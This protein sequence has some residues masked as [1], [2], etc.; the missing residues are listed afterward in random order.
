MKKSPV[1]ILFYYFFFFISCQINEKNN[2][3]NFGFERYD[4]VSYKPLDWIDCGKGSDISIDSSTVFEGN[5]SLKVEKSDVSGFGCY[6]YT[7]PVSFEGNE[8]KLTAF[9]KLQNVN[10]GFAGISLQIDGDEGVL[11]HDNMM[12]QNLHGTSDWGKYT[13]NLKL[14][15]NATKIHIGAYLTGGGNIWVDNFQLR[16]D[17]KDISQL[18]QK[19]KT[20]KPDFDFSE[21]SGVNL[22]NLSEV[23][24]KNAVVLGQIWGF[25]KYHH[26]MVMKGNFN[27]DYELFMIMQNV[28]ESKNRNERN[29]I[30][31][32]WI[33]GF[34]VIEN[35]GIEDTL[36][37]GKI[38]SNPNFSWMNNEEISNYPVAEE[39]KKINL[40]KSKDPQSYVTLVPGA[41]NPIF[42]NE[43]EYKN[44]GYP[45]A[46]FRLLAL[47]RFWN[48][49]QYFYPYFYLIEH[50]WN[51]VLYE[52]VPKFINASNELEYKLVLLELMSKVQDSHV[53][54][55]GN[56]KTLGQFWG[57][58][59]APLELRFIDE[60]LVITKILEPAIKNDVDIKIGDQIT[61]IDGIGIDEI[62]S[63]KLKYIPGSNRQTKLRDIARKIIRSNG[64]KMNLTLER[65]TYNWEIEFKLVDL[66]F[67]YQR[68]LESHKWVQEDIGYIYPGK[69]RQ[70]EIEDIMEKF[71]D[72]KGIIVDLRCYPSDFI[73]FSLGKYLMDK[74]RNFVKFTNANLNKPGLFTFTESLSVGEIN[75]NS[76]KGKVIIIIDETTQS[77]AEYTAM[78]LRVAPNALVVGSNSAGADGNV[79]EVL[80]PG[81]IVTY[82]TGIGVY[83]PDGTE[84]QRIGIVP[85]IEIK[86][87]IEG[88]RNN[89]DEPL[90]K[91]VE[92]I[93][94]K[95]RESP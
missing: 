90:T 91:A 65:T 88:I 9:L 15:D 34:G 62:L 5:Y 37:Q 54:I 58:K 28:Y 24:I 79:S 10:N 84:T 69:L 44:L 42:K 19:P 2:I 38:K 1:L 41:R 95:L 13:I 29:L 83:Y 94:G 39:L 30:L 48:I 3:Y 21:N 87:T 25:L 78:A 36:Q 16:I 72:A 59:M 40:K 82:I 55:I 63:Q 85:D 17:D 46:G 49:I 81:G 70:G 33:K 6:A 61:K 75:N 57:T 12:D 32:D 14:P 56:D 89:I 18:S 11:E 92:L 64:E 20:T 76:Y 27:W 93:N 51:E 8:I 35:Y 45:D 74:P 4:K 68:S 77:Q 23:N 47:Y 7:I 60:K 26:P 66:S 31:Y 80:L 53:Q 71:L 22:E 52:F 43:N 73:V 86:P 50:D 67:Q